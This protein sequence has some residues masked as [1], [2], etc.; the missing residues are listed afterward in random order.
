MITL[1]C[2]GFGEIQK[3][4]ITI[5]KEGN[6]G[7]RAVLCQCSIYLLYYRASRRHRMGTRAEVDKISV[8]GGF[9]ITLADLPK[10]RV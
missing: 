6:R 1:G 2:R 7:E 4:C 5:E 9:C 8:G 3:D 10:S